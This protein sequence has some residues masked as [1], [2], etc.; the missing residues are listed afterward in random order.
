MET[1]NKIEELINNNQVTWLW[2]Q[3]NLNIYELFFSKFDSLKLIDYKLDDRLLND[4]TKLISIFNANIEESTSNLDFDAAISDP[5]QNIFSIVRA[6][7]DSIVHRK[8]K[9]IKRK[10]SNYHFINQ[11]IN[12]MTKIYKLNL[13]LGS[14][15]QT[16]I[17]NN[18]NYASEVDALFIIKLIK[19]RFF[20]LYAPKISLVIISSSCVVYDIDFTK[21]NSNNYFEVIVSPDELC[22]IISEKHNIDNINPERIKQYLRLCN[23]DL[24]LID[25]IISTTKNN[26]SALTSDGIE[27]TLERIIQDV[28]KKIPDLNVLEI[29]AVIGLSFDITTINE[30]S[31]YPMDKLVVRLNDAYERG[32]LIKPEN[33]EYNFSFISEM[34]RETIYNGGNIDHQWHFRYAEKLSKISPYE[35]ALIAKHYYLGNDI[36]KAV[37]N[38]VSYLV[39]CTIDDKPINNNDSAIVKIK[40]CI[41]NNITISAGLS[42][43]NECLQRYKSG[44]ISLNELNIY[45]AETVLYIDRL[46]CFTK[47]AIIYHGKLSKSGSDFINL[48]NS[49]KDSYTY[50]EQIKCIG[51]QIRCGLYLTDIYSYRLNMLEDASKFNRKLDKLTNNALVSTNIENQSLRVMLR[52]KT[53]SQLSPELANERTKNLLMECIQS[54]ES[55]DDIEIYKL[56]SDCLG[57]ALYS[58][59]YNNLPNPI[60]QKAKEY[61]QMGVNL[62]YPKLYKLQMNY[63]LL[64]IFTNQITNTELE[65]WLRN[66][67]SR[68]NNNASMYDYDLA[69]IALLCNHLD[70][71]EKILMKLYKELENNS[72]CFY[73]YCYCANLVSLYLLRKDYSTAKIYN[74]LIICKEYQWEQNFIDIMKYRAKEMDTFITNKKVFTPRSLFECFDDIPLKYSNTWRFLG[75][76]ILFS[77]LMFY[78]E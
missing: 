19:S 48:A 77:E 57:Y 70:F 71:A 34:I 31:D 11:E 66:Q 41:D 16:I 18:F 55:I 15:K 64:R 25:V 54:G 14:D 78:R 46:V 68:S 26:S 29:A 72:T 51:M 32:L 8:Y 6:C 59:M 56:T 22:K 47:A 3:Q 23:N 24:N 20:E 65:R 67:E 74:D 10:F 39:V 62:N 49:I 7:W 73:N 36:E 43:I 30:I 42:Q 58:G 9:K 28:L 12:L 45:A 53:S 63:L 33:Q 44:C 37:A 27:I 50:F 40:S 1:V 35:F 75:K 2:N 13:K 61:L 5:K 38:Y 69:A 60:K 4:Y 21:I 17:I 76:G 52:R